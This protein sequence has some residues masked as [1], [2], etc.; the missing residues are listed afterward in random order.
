[1]LQHSG[2]SS[3]LVTHK[4]RGNSRSASDR[5]HEQADAD[6]LSDTTQ[7]NFIFKLALG[8]Q[9]DGQQYPFLFGEKTK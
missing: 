5:T 1:M 6:A 3:V 2:V 7:Y 4:T 9:C 8:I